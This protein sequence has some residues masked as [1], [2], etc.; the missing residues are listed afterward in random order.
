MFKVLLLGD[1]AVGKSNLVHQFVHGGTGPGPQHQTV[2]VDFITV[3]VDASSFTDLG[4]S[5]SEAAAKSGAVVSL[6]LWDTAG[7]EKFA[8]LASTVYRGAHAAIVVFDLTE[9]SSFDD[10]EKW[11]ERV[12]SRA[13]GRQFVEGVHPKSALA[14]GGDVEFPPIVLVGNKCDLIHI[15]AIQQVEGVALAKKLGAVA[16]FET[17]AST[18]ANV[19]KPFEA[20]AFCVREWCSPIV[21]AGV[22]TLEAEHR[23]RRKWC[24]ML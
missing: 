21:A 4:R 23:H 10:A 13:H 17:S 12:R 18:G 3:D 16:Y 22:A 7:E 14:G 24:T 5:K 19:E 2:G 9:R 15:R 6:Q 1:S 20:V 11:V 8:A